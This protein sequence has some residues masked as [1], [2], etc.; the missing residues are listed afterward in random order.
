MNHPE[1][2]ALEYQPKVISP[3][4]H[5]HP[6]EEM[7]S[8]LVVQAWA[9]PFR[10]PNRMEATLV[11]QEWHSANNSS[12]TVGHNISSFFKNCAWKTSRVWFS[13]QLHFLNKGPEASGETQAVLIHLNQPSPC[14]Y[15]LPRRP[16]LLPWETDILR[17][18]SLNSCMSYSLK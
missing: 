12:W 16:E 3:F 5:L 17:L 13:Y 18:N 11:P 8:L 10:M 15:F 7:K 2:S 6:G 1:E 4:V 9:R 14:S